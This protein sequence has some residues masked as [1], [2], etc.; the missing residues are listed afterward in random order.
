MR[1]RKLRTGRAVE[2]TGL[3]ALRARRMSRAPQSHPPA[4]PHRWG[5]RP[6][7]T[8]RRQGISRNP[9]RGTL[10]PHQQCQRFWCQA[11]SQQV[12]YTQNV[13]DSNGA[14]NLG[15]LSYGQAGLSNMNTLI[16]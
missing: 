16:V 9:A 8:T 5:R 15:V 4:E 11:N 12:L 6:S 1:L 10:V 14:V 2:P 13:G 7:R 3:P